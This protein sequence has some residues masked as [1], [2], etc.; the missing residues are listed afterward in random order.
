[1]SQMKEVDWT[2]NVCERAYTKHSKLRSLNCICV[3]MSEVEKAATTEQAYPALFNAHLTNLSNLIRQY[4]MQRKK[5]E[6]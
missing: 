2:C 4:Q 5:E 3:A 1:M 6:A